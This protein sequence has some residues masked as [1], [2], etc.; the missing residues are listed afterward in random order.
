VET[1]WH[2]PQIPGSADHI[3]GSLSKLFDFD[4]HRGHN[5]KLFLDP[6]TGTT[7]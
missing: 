6:V 2:L 5:P 3:A 4:D 7:T 1:N